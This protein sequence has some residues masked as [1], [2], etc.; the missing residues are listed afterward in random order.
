MG[1]AAA[2]NDIEGGGARSRPKRSHAI[3]NIESIVEAATR[4]LAVDPDASINEIA[5]AAGV[6]RATLYGHFASRS[7]LV[8]EVVE[9]AM[10]QT[11][12]AL[13]RIDLDGDPR[14]VLG[15]VLERTWQLT[16]RFGAIVL[17]GIQ[18]MPPDDVR[19]AHERP[20]ARVRVLLERGRAEGE[21]GDSTSVE[22]QLD[23]IQAIV[24]GA[25]VAVHRGYL[26]VQ[27]APRLVRETTLAALSV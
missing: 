12:E 15:R 14:E 9:R 24:H 17:A 10:A 5:Q 2:V 23:L 20:A 18:S 13:A 22:W 21:F 11:E 4:L 7:A 6:G 1:D 27:D 8:S 26:T 19:R 3:R 25:S 16:H